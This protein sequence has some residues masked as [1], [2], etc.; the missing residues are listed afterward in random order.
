[1]P[2]GVVRNAPVPS[3]YCSV[4]PAP[5]IANVPEFVIGEP[6]TVNAEGA[7]KPTLDTP[8]PG[9]AASIVNVLLPLSVKVIFDPACITTTSLVASEPVIAM[10]IFPAAPT[11]P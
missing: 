1:M 8:P 11:A 9:I 2:V 7:V 5:V 6:V 3:M 4:V 10:L